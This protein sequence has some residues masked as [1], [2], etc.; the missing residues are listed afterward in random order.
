MCTL[1]HEQSVYKTGTKNGKKSYS[2]VALYFNAEVY[3]S[4]SSVQERY[5][6]V[7]LLYSKSRHKK[8]DKEGFSCSPMAKDS[9]TLVC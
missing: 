5:K 2:F 1:F 8:R 7:C 3:Q 6:M 9:G 4:L